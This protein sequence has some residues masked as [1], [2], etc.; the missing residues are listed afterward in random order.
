[1][2]TISLISQKGGVGKTTLAINLAAAAADRGKA[3]LIAD[4]DP[5]Q[6][7]HRWYEGRK[8]EHP[9][10]YVASVFPDA[11]P[12]FAEKARVNGADYLFID[13]SPNSTETSLAIADL[14]DLLVVPCGPSFVDLRALK[15]TENVVRLSAKPALAALNLCPPRGD[16]PDQAERALE[17][18]G[19]EV[20]ARRIGSRAAARRAYALNQSVLEFE[21]DGKS[22]L[23]FNLLWKEIEAHEALRSRSHET[24]TRREH[25]AVH[26]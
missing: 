21:P 12:S 17:T 3:V 11:L 10:P 9:L 1:M 7:V 20:A 25:E 5:Q 14:S 24:M 18:L 6:S 8:A 15:R 22:A 19:F 2:K 4:T 26:G 16:E 13:S 23:E